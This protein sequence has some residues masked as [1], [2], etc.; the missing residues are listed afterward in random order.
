M[1]P[2]F[3]GHTAQKQK[4][5]RVFLVDPFSLVRLSVAEWLRWTPDL[6]VCGQAETTDQALKAIRRLKPD[7]VVTEMFSKK[8]FK[9]IQTLHK[10]DPH[11]PILVFSCGSE[12]WRAPRAL[13]AG[14]DGFLLKG[15]SAHGLIDGI[16]RALEGRL[17]LS[18]E[19]RYQLL[20]KCA[21]SG[22]PHLM[23]RPGRRRCRHRAEALRMAM[24]FV[25]SWT[26]HRN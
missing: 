16:R 5:R 10:E 17:V 6:I 3:A 14:A 11:L 18:S 22:P 2:R 25:G 4:P 12:T 20:V 26:G 23:R 13:E 21:P 15:A 9:F 24:P 7:I 8:D 19:M 1:K